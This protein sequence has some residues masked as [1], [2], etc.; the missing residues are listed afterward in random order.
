MGF[1]DFLK[2]KPE[3]SDAQPEAKKPEPKARPEDVVRAGMPADVA[4]LVRAGLP[5]GPTADEAVALFMQLRS[6]PDEARGVE[7]LVRTA[8]IRRL[9]EELL[10]VLG[11]ALVDR[12]ELEVASR[13]MQ[14]ATSSPALVLLADL[15]ERRGDL[16]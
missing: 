14:G 16:P 13:V 3:A 4:R 10:L 12:G 9:P 15:A 11:G 8:Q 5:G 1:W 2:K 6:T 7:E